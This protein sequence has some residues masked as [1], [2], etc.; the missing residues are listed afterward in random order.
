[1]LFLE[2]SS[3]FPWEVGFF[4]REQSY[5]HGEEFK[6]HSWCNLNFF[7]PREKMYAKV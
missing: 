2:E 6:L 5:P 4:P 7:F 1:M 3:L